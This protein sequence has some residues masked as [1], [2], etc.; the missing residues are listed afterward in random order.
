MIS[1]KIVKKFTLEGK[2]VI[3]RYPKSKD[4]LGLQKSINSLVKEKA[5]ML[6]QKKFTLK[7]EAAWLAEKLK[8]IEKK[9][10]VFLVVEWGGKIMGSAEVMKRKNPVENHVGDLAI[11]LNR[12]IRGKGVGEKLLKAVI[13][14]AR[15]VL[16]VKIIISRVMGSNKIAKRLYKKAGFWQA[17]I[18]KKALKHYDRYVEEITMA[19]YL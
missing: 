19:K 15:T 10:V 8:E 6:V 2:E 13:K 14:E 9:T 3:F 12:E 18:I 16:G 11:S 1:G 5:M 7:E 4:L 17:G